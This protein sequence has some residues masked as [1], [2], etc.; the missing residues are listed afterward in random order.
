MQRFDRKVADQLVL[1]GQDSGHVIAFNIAPHAKRFHDRNVRQEA[2]KL[3]AAAEG[4][5]HSGTPKLA[6]GRGLLMAKAP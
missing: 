1:E 4:L 2:F 6:F 3:S 5:A